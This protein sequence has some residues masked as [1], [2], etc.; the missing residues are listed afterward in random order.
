MESTK[1]IFI[2]YAYCPEKATGL[3]MQKYRDSFNLYCKNFCVGLV[4]LKRDNPECSVALVT[5]ID[6]PD[7]YAE[8]LK[9]NNVL[10]YKEEYN[11]FKFPDNHKWSG[12]FYKLNALKAMIENYNYEYYCYM[13]TD[14]ICNK[15]LDAVWKEADE[16]ILLYDINHGLNVR[17]Y[18]LF[19]D[20]VNR[21]IGENTYTT[22]YGG[23][24]FAANVKNAKL[25]IDEA[26]KIYN[27]II[28]RNYEFSSGD[29][30]IISLT[31][32]SL[33]ELIKNA[34]AYIF[35]FWTDRDFRLVSTCYKY[36]AVSLLHLPSEKNRG[37]VKIFNKYIKKNKIPSKR[38]IY[39]ICHLNTIGYSAIIKNFLSGI[40]N[41]IIC[42]GDRKK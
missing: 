8:I 26:Q 24:F 5:N 30:F 14:V 25:F 7:E 15:S 20:E 13:D 38:K 12:A 40:Y 27:E 11:S 16:N 29:E 18:N 28:N 35:R 6:I 3:N 42:K 9:Q 22:H 17:D 4:T 21:F 31:A 33:K 39:K 23:E 32:R 37:I 1:L 34:G 19:L 10:I 2:S 41:F 36:N